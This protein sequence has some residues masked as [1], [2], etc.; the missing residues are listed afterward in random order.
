MYEILKLK[1][2]KPGLSKYINLLCID[3]L[4]FES[5]DIQLKTSDAFL[6]IVLE[7]KKN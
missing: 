5:C 4:I 2:I 6:L 1:N 7:F 3:W